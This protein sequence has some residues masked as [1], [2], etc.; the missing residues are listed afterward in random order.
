MTAS[1]EVH[2][3][4]GE[5]EAGAAPDTIVARSTPPGSSLKA[6]VRLSGPASLDLSRPLLPEHDAERLEETNFRSMQTNLSLVHPRPLTLPAT[7]LVMKASRSYTCE[8]TV[9]IQLPGSLPL[10]EMLI[11][12]FLDLGARL[13]EPG[14]F[15]ERAFLNGRLDL[16]RAEAVLSLIEARDQDER[17]MAVHQLEG[18]LHEKIEDLRERLTHLCAYVESAL[19]F[20]DQDID[21]IDREGIRSYLDPLIERVED[22]LETGRSEQPVREDPR[23]V[24]YGRPNVGKSRLFNRLIDEDRSIVTE[25]A[26]TTRDVIEGTLVEASATIRLFDT[27]GVAETDEAERDELESKMVDRAR[28][29]T[30]EADFLLHLEDARTVLE[31]ARFPAP[32]QD[33]G[34]TAVRV[35]IASRV[36][37]L[38]STERNQ[39]ETLLADQFPPRDR[40]VTSARTG[41]GVSDLRRRMREILSDTAAQEGAFRLNLRHMEHLDEAREHLR[42]ASGAVEDGRPYELIAVDLRDGLECLGKIVGEVGVEGILDVIFSEFCIGK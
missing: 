28:R 30:R 2:A 22:L 41:E 14:E 21:V 35:P 19:D 38:N 33:A 8:D 27:A 18:R 37:R 9:E 39:L 31:N 42:R 11:E 6:V 4:P 5:R 23:G 32:D 40:I 36:D 7:L 13:A 15:T 29:A 26:G 16:T 3:S 1:T 20:S 12:Q 24:L 17:E 34:Q 10:V 25:I